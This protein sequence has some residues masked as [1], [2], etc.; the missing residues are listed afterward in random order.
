MDKCVTCGQELHPERAKKYNYCMSPE[1]QEKNA[2]G[3]TMVA[4]GVNKAA[5]QYMILDERTKEE[6]ASG[7]YRDQRREL[8]GGSGPSPAPATNTAPAPA[9]KA[10]TRSRP[11]T[12]KAARQPWSRSQ[13][14]LAL[15]YN[16]QGLRPDEIAQKL[17]LSAYAATQI[18]LDARSRGKL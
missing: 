16:E 11:A 6:L 3:L 13:Q 5:E 18:I 10:R 17:G 7:K 8:F 14:K 2:K 9:R 12:R 1:C 4:V 15:L